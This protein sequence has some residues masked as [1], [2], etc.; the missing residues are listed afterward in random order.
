MRL[1]N[2]LR[3]RIATHL[4]DKVMKPKLLAQQ[5][6]EEAFGDSVYDELYTVEERRLM[7]ALPKGALPTCDELWTRG[8]SIPLSGVRRIFSE[9][10]EL[11]KQQLER[12]NEFTKGKQALIQEQNSLYKSTFGVLHSVTTV[13]KL[14]QVWPEVKETVEQF[15]ALPTPNLPALPVGEL[16]KKL[17]LP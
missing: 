9:N 10:R 7:E 5:K 8:R 2:E 1:T 11:S 4:V 16:N 3:E 12:W 14:I 6:A 15:I 17:G 13:K